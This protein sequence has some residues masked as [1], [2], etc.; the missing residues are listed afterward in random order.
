MKAYGNI[1]LDDKAGLEQAL[2]TLKLA[3]YKYKE[4]VYEINEKQRLQS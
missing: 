4:F 2:T 1:L 3:L